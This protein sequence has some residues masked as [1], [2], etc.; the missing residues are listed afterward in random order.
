MKWRKKRP[1]SDWRPIGQP[2]AWTRIDPA[3]SLMLA[4]ECR[5]AA[6]RLA[7]PDSERDMFEAGFILGARF[8]AAADECRIRGLEARRGRAGS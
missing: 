3:D 4:D 5:R 2:E 1:A 6:N 7:V 8:R